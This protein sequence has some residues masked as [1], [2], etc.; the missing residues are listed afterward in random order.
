MIQDTHAHSN[1][2]DNGLVWQ[3]LVWNGEA[4]AD[5]MQA[6]R[7]LAVSYGLFSLA[8]MTFT[9]IPYDALGE[10]H[11]AVIIHCVVFV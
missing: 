5:G 10:M 4:A 9:V 2:A 7:W 3:E 6:I 11:R 1:L 8:G